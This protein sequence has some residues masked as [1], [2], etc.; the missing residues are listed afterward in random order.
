MMRTEPSLTENNSKEIS[1]FVD[2]TSLTDDL[3][4]T[5][6]T[7]A[8]HV[9]GD[10]VLHHSIEQQGDSSEQDVKDTT[11]AGEFVENNV[12]FSLTNDNAL[13]LNANEHAGDLLSIDSAASVDGESDIDD[14]PDVFPLDA[15]ITNKNTF[16]DAIQNI[17]LAN[18]FRSVQYL[19]YWAQGFASS[20]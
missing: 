19:S 7:N 6:A 9:R 14:V 4:W 1:S 5:N 10:H 17:D 13:V 16:K 3:V 11:S 15:T 2:K 8:N 20:S 18:F 12:S